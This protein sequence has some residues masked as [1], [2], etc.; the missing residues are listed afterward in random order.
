[1]RRGAID[2]ETWPVVVVHTRPGDVTIHDPHLM[3]AAPPP[4]GGGGGRRTLYLGYGRADAHDLLGPGRS[5][6]DL[7]SATADDGFVSFDEGANSV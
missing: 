2:E 5:F 3:H 4:Q 6:D 1:V 7:L